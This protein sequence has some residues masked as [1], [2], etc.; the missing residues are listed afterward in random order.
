MKWR[1][2]PVSGASPSDSECSESEEEGD[3]PVDVDNPVE[4]AGGAKKKQGVKRGITEAARNRIKKTMGAL[5]EICT[6]LGV[7]FG[8]CVLDQSKDKKLWDLLEQVCTIDTA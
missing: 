5:G 7:I 4:P 2:K 1:R 3:V 8:A 6:G